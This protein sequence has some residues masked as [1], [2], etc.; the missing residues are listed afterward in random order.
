MKFFE[1]SAKTADKIDEAFMAIAKD[2]MKKRDLQIAEKKKN[3]KQNKSNE[4][5]G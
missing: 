4:P 5:F 2:L 1:V 3:R